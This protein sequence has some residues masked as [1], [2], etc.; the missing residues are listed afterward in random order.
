MDEQTRI[1]Q[2]TEQAY[3][4]GYKDGVHDC[5]ETLQNEI[6]MLRMALGI[7]LAKCNEAEVG[8]PKPH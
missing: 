8:C 4:A 6:E 1:D 7:A 3:K 2:A 5:T